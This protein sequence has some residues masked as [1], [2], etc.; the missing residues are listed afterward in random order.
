M[1][2]RGRRC[3]IEEVEGIGWW[4]VAWR[5]FVFARGHALDPLEEVLDSGE[6]VGKAPRVRAA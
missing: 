6:R 2:L 5:L 1:I 4:W 3:H